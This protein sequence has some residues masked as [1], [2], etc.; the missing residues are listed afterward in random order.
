MK[1]EFRGHGRAESLLERLIPHFNNELAQKMI[2]EANVIH[3]QLDGRTIPT[4]PKAFTIKNFHAE[5]AYWTIAFSQPVIQYVPECFKYITK[6]IPYHFDTRT[7]LEHVPSYVLN[8]NHVTSQQIY[9]SGDSSYGDNSDGL[10]AKFVYENNTPMTLFS[11]NILLPEYSKKQ[12]LEPSVHNCVQKCFELCYW[13]FPTP[14]IQ[15]DGSCINNLIYSTT[16]K[17]RGVLALRKTLVKILE[18]GP[19]DNWNTLL[20]EPIQVKNAKVMLLCDDGEKLTSQEKWLWIL[21]HISEDL[22][23]GDILNAVIIQSVTG[24]KTKNSIIIGQIGAKV[25]PNDIHTIMSLTCSKMMQDVNST[26]SS[27]KVTDINKLESTISDLFKNNSLFFAGIFEWKINM[28]KIHKSA[29]LLF[30]IFLENDNNLYHFHPTLVSF[31]ATHSPQTLN[32]KQ[33]L[34]LIVKLFDVLEINSEFW[35]RKAR[36]KLRYSENYA[37]IQRRDPKFAKTL[38]DAIP[39]LINQIIY[40]RVL[41][42]HYTHTDAS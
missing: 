29:D 1:T 3:R 36:S 37:E 25:T 38:L 39:R 12:F 17:I 11:Y 18:I 41:S 16:K 4:E 27:T 23:E 21:K 22:D 28:S 32:D 10:F 13:R 40:S 19:R 26:T 15:D 6:N 42:R 2:I 8:I 33:L 35:G 14:T 7:W 34:L 9:N 31:I 30:P 24:K 20:E 5:V